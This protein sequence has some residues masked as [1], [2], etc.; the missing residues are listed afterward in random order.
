VIP[1]GVVIAGGLALASALAPRRLTRVLARLACS[2]AALTVLSYVV[3]AYD[4]VPNAPLATIAA[5]AL[6]TLLALAVP[7]TTSR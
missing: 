3:V 5:G 6:A 4:P 1:W 2:I 7:R